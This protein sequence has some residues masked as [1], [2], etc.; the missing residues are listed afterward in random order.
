MALAMLAHFWLQPGPLSDKVRATLLAGVILGATALLFLM[1]Q[2]LATGDFLYPFKRALERSNAPPG[3]VITWGEITRLQVGRYWNYYGPLTTALTLYWLGRRLL[4]RPAWRAADTWAVLIWAPGLVYGFLLR[5]VAHQHD[6]LMLG[7]APGA[8]LMATLGLIQVLRDISSLAGQRHGPRLMGAALALLLAVH[9][10]GAVRSARN[11]EEQEALDLEKG[12]SRMAFHLRALP[13]D[14]LLAADSSARMAL[15]H[16]D[17]DGHDYVSLL[18]FLDYFARRPTHAADDLQALGRL[19]CEATRS[20][21]PLV[22]LQTGTQRNQGSLQVPEDWVSAS[23][24][25]DQT[26]AVHLA[27]RPLAT[28]VEAPRR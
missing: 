19:A 1:Q 5:D 24:R 28:C 15:R 2:G 12:A 6:F 4:P 22:L 3:S 21:R 14:T 25:F 17:R 7:L 13:A 8:A 23:Y 27:P 11:F 9:A 10:L 18:P 26:Y 16:D 20:G